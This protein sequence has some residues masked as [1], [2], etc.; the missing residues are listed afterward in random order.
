MEVDTAQNDIAISQE[1]TADYWRE[2]S[3][4]LEEWV[5]E[6][7]AKNQALR[8]EMEHE[9][10]LPRYRLETSLSFSSLSVYRSSFS[11]ARPALQTEPSTLVVNAGEASCPR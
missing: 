3:E 9:R 8:M 4:C 11:S 2:R 7:L 6:L 10:S 5:C 1:R